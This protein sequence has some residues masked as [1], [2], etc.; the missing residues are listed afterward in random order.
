MRSSS[1]A[2]ASARS[3]AVT[4]RER[5]GSRSKL[6]VLDK[7]L[8]EDAEDDILPLLDLR[9]ESFGAGVGGAYAAYRNLL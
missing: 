1:K 7:L 9:T 4:V 8:C 2:S 5:S 3:P 6:A